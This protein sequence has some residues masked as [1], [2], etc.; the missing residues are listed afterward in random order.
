MKNGQILVH[1]EPGP[2]SEQ[3]LR[4]ALSMARSRDMKLIG[5]AVRL[6]AAA[7]VTTTMG[8]AT[9]TAALCETSGECCV[10]AKALFDSAT[11]GSG[12]AVE[13]REVCGVPLNVIT[14]EAG[15]ADFVIV[16]QNDRVDTES[17][18]Y[19]LAPADLIM[20]CGT[21]VIV[22]S[23]DAPLS[24]KARRILLAWKSTPQAARAVRDALPL[25]MSAE[26]VVLTEVVSDTDGGKYE[27]SVDAMAS[28]LAAHGVEVSIRRL[29]ASGDTGYQLI[30]AAADEECD[31]IVAGAYGHSR[32]REWV[33]GG[34]T[35]SLL[36]ASTIPCILS[37]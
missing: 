25:L 16:G 8:D 15:R 14:A 20:A 26:T 2:V 21:P 29:P 4:Y 35:R 7:A 33:L 23:A 28:Y 22:V 18:V 12:I 27:I 37:H 34:V 32:V 31:F 13:W 17:N 9:A 30:V 36:A 3:R 6:S 1:V 19:Q 11:R 5:L 24:Y 10:T